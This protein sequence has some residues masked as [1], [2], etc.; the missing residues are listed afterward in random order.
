MIWLERFILVAPSVWPGADLPLGIPELLLGAGFAALFF[1]LFAKALDRFPILPLTDPIF[2]GA[3]T[4]H[5]LLGEP[6][7]WRA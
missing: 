6:E 2:T 1:L 5:H 4:P 3:K 7:Q